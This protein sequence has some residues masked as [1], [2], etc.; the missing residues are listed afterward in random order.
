MPELLFYRIHNDCLISCTQLQE[1]SLG[2]FR[3]FDCK[4]IWK[5]TSHQSQVDLLL[6]VSLALDLCRVGKRQRLAEKQIRFGHINQRAAQHP[7]RVFEVGAEGDNSGE[8]EDL[9]M[10]TAFNRFV[11]R[12]VN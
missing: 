5:S 2:V 4:S 3:E 11:H 8:V 10:H 9:R 1:L 7:S 12:L 6:D